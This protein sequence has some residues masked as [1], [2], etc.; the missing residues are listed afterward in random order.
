MSNMEKINQV[1]KI[2]PFLHLGN[3]MKIFQKDYIETLGTH[4]SAKSNGTSLKIPHKQTPPKI[5]GSEIFQK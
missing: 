4:A 5:L 2:L 3:K 1:M